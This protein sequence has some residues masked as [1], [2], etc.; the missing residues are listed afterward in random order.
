MAYRY[1]WIAGDTQIE[2][3]SDSTY[4]PSVSDVGKTIKVKVSF[5][6]DV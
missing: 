4:K 5:T 3:A 6:D 1:Q 2:D